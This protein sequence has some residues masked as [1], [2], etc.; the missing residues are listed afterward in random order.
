M[1]DAFAPA[2]IGGVA[3]RNRVL[4]A[5][6]FE[7]MCTDGVPTEALV[8]HHRD[9]ARGGVALTTV[10]HAAVS[11]EGRNHRAQLWLR[12]EAVARLRTLVSAVR[13]EGAAAS[14]Q[15][16][17]A[18]YDADPSVTGSEPIGPSA[19]RSRNR[20]VTARRMTEVEVSRIVG[21]YALAAGFAVAAEFDAVELQ[22]GHGML[23]SQ[24]LS[25]FTNRRDDRWGGSL[26]N[27]MRLGIEIIRV[28]RSVIGPRRALIVRFN[29]VDGFDDGIELEEGVEMATR[30]GRESVDALLPSAG[31]EGKL[32][33]FGI[34]GTVPA[35]ALARARASALAKLGTLVKSGLLEKGYPFEPMYL[36]GHAQAVRRAVKVPVVLVGGLRSRKHLDVAMKAGFGFVAMARPLVHDPAIVKR[37]GGRELPG[38]SCVPCNECLGVRPDG[39]IACPNRR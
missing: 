14:I 29:V 8:A 36:L 35:L 13:Y 27:R 5:A 10:A 32:S 2:K 37:M 28:V 34:R 9:L 39:G 6:T 22:F 20:S 4:Q 3:L 16:V 30:F 38:S 31:F 33:L 25:S 15:L 23:V 7:G 26:D 1:S 24:F 21:D 19:V 11:G 17:H 18:G 12:D